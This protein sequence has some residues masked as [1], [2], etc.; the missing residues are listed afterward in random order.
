MASREQ[1]RRMLSEAKRA[2]AA[3]SK[4]RCIRRSFGLNSQ[5]RF[6]PKHNPTSTMYRLG[7]DNDGESTLR[8]ELQ[9]DSSCE[10][11]ERLMAIEDAVSRGIDEQTARTALGMY[12]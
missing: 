7:M 3:S 2:F 12:R 9:A 10:P 11:L 8:L 4:V 5:E 1:S 6:C